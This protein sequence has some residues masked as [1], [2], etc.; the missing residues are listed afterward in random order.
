M[1][2]NDFKRARGEEGGG[3]GERKGGDI[4]YNSLVFLYLISSYILKNTQQ[5]IEMFVFI[6]HFLQEE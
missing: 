6:K 5:Q 4:S 3:R 2:G 1:E